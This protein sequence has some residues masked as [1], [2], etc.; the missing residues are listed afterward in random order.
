MHLGAE[1][2]LEGFFLSEK[3]MKRKQMGEEKPRGLYEWK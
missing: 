2:F 1:F 3:K